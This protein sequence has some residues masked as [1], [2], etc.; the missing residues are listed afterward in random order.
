MALEVTD[1]NIT[2]VITD[3]QITVVDKN[4]INE[5]ISISEDSKQTMIAGSSISRACHGKI[6]K[7]NNR[8]F[9]FKNNE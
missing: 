1:G 8:Y 7:T 4:I 6:K 5:F 3:N 9:K 2:Q